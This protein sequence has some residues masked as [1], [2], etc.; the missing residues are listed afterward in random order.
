MNPLTSS[1]RFQVLQAKR[2]ASGKQISKK[3]HA[4]R[5]ACG[6]S[7]DKAQDKHSRTVGL[8]ARHFHF[9]L[10]TA[11]LKIK[12]KTGNPPSQRSC[13]AT[14]CGTRPEAG[15]KFTMVELLVVIAIIAILAALLLP[16]LDKAKKVTW[17]ASC[18]N[19]LKQVGTFENLYAMDADGWTYAG[20]QTTGSDWQKSLTGGVY[21]G[22]D[23]PR[24]ANDNILRCPALNSPAT[25]G[26]YG[27]ETS[28]SWAP[29]SGSYMAVL[30]PAK[31]KYHYFYRPEKFVSSWPL[32]ADSRFSKSY[33]EKKPYELGS[34][35]GIWIKTS[36][37]NNDWKRGIWLG[38]LNTANVL[39]PDMHASS[40]NKNELY[41]NYG[42]TR[43]IMENW[44]E[45][46]Y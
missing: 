7:F 17:R 37:F 8:R 41:K 28:I 5:T 13:G 9:R 20:Y 32:F 45:L 23:F 40:H 16:A 3:I 44:S 14:I 39:F 21:G 12:G 27:I 46:E 15:N 36:W 43:M 30:N 31:T 22:Y 34:Q 19:N 38:H 1:I 10:P 2:S 24:L 26:T 29:P 35:S 11:I 18:L 25:P 6:E 33:C 4:Y 42:I